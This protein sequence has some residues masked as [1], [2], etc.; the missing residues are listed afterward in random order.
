MIVWLTNVHVSCWVSFEFNLRR[1][2]TTR[3][4]CWK[5]AKMLGSVQLFTSTEWNGMKWLLH[6]LSAQPALVRFSTSELWRAHE[7]Q[8][9]EAPI[10]RAQ[11]SIRGSVQA[12][13]NQAFY[14]SDKTELMQASK[15]LNPSLNSIGKEHVTLGRTTYNSCCKDC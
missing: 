12:P 11:K 15:R 14:H 2:V 8:S 6:W 10:W 9:E 7:E 5:V 4:C 1:C 13:A 3:F